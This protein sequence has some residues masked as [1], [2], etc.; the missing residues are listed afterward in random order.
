MEFS[1]LA[2][3]QEWRIEDGLLLGYSTDA[4]YALCRTET[5]WHY[6]RGNAALFDRRMKKGMFFTQNNRG[7]FRKKNGSFLERTA[8]ALLNGI[9]GLLGF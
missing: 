5:F 8:N 3:G 4:E 6:L 7:D 1:S 2:D 9:G